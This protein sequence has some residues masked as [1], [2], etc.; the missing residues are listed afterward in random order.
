MTTMMTKGTRTTRKTM[1]KTRLMSEE[2]RDDNNDNGYSDNDSKKKDNNL[3]FDA[4]TN[5]VIG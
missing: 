3:I 2:E 5:F 4:T 1:T